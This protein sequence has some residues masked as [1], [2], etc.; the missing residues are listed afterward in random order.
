M[1]K[2]LLVSL[3]L[4]VFCVTQVF[5][6][7]RTITGTVT[8][9]DD[10]QPIPGVT[11]KIKGSNVGVPTDVN[12]KYS[13]NA[14]AG[15][16]LMFSFISYLTQEVSVGDRSV[17]NVSLAPDNKQLNEVLV[18]GYGQTTRQAYVGSAKAVSGE[19]LN[20][21]RV[22]NITQA[23]A[24]EVAG[25][26]VVNTSGQPGTVA[27]VRIRGFGS[28]NGNRDPLYVVDGVPYTGSLNAINPNDVESTTV[29]KDATATA[30]YGSRGSAGVIVITTKSGKNKKPYVEA[31]VNFGTNK[32]LIP[33]YDVITSP[34]QYVG[35]SWEG[36]YNEGVAKGNANPTNYANTRLF[37]SAGLP[38]HFNIWNLTGP[39]LV[40]PATRTVK[41]DAVRKYTP[42]KW[43]DYAFQSA[44]RT[45][46][47]VSLGG[48][49]ETSGYY[50][51][52]GYE[53]SKGYSIASDFQ[54]LTGRLNL[55][56]QIKPWLEAKMTSNFAHSKQNIG[57]QTE[58]S[59]S[60]FWFVDN[61]PPIYGL[62]LRDASGNFVPD[63]IFGGNQYDYGANGRK[64]GS[65]T[66]SIADTKYNTNRNDRNEFNGTA[67]LNA[68]I[69]PGLTFENTFGLQYYDLLNTQLTN[70]YYGSSASQNGSIYLHRNNLTNWDLL[71]LVRYKK[72]FGEHNIEAFVAHEATKWSHGDQEDFKYNLILN[73]SESLNNA[74]VSTPAT[75][76][77]EGYAIESYFGQINYDYQDK[78]FLLGSI[79]RDGSSRFLNNKWGTFGSIGAG[80]LISSEEFM[81]DQT[82][83]SSLKLKASYGT[84]GDQ[85]GVG[86]YSGYNLS[87]ISNAND[88][89]SIGVPDK[90]NPNLTWESSKILQAGVEFDLGRYLTG[91]LEYYVKNTSNLIFDQKK[92]LSNGYTQI[93]V[94]DGG[95]RNQGLEFDLVGHLV[96]NKD[97]R[98]DLGVN[99]EML[100]NRITSM[101]IDPTTGKQ[102]PI[103]TNSYYGW[104]AG[105]SI[106]DFY[107]RKS[108]GVNPADGRQSWDAYYVD[109]DGDGVAKSGAIESNTGEYIT[110]LVAYLA[111]HPDQKANIKETTTTTYT[112][113]A[114]QYVGK[115][116][117][118]TVR[119]A[120]NLN[121]GY[122][123]FDLSVQFLYSVGGYSYD[124]AYNTLMGNDLV[125]DNNWSTDILKRWQKPGDKTDVPRISDDYDV[126]STGASSRFITKA[127]YIQLNNVRLSY[128]FSK[129]MTAKW[130]VGSLGVFVSGDNL[131]M[132]SARKG[133]NP[134]NAED[135]L[136]S[137]YN[138][139]PLS[140][141]SAGLNVRF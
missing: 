127:S 72:Q 83:F 14:P 71:N 52:L 125:G 58:D 93:T 139:S 112:N 82:I 24:G 64:F 104:S 106:Y 75:S 96:R 67:S 130:G 107:M 54:R 16:T 90:G 47:N 59:G 46:T 86:Y 66:N 95:L 135:G 92:P 132:H 33:R 124:A 111:A 53:N 105:H 120:V 50:M 94:N 2:L 36:L 128:T 70:K 27:T 23:L 80:W 65:L 117:V 49:T 122:K 25:V 44:S 137:I 55:N 11:V 73:N 109:L 100:K 51:S 89:R 110:N 20:K 98:L 38:S 61:L 63:P 3:C 91:S 123:G 84:V 133:F 5:A 31:N 6:Q 37:S 119:G 13:I 116:F 35:L 21:K 141:L 136:S 12:G 40:D 121:A 32:N 99:G 42:E 69:I 88:N 8:G 15:S 134:G 115:S 7:N 97:F 48:G 114:L 22:D 131:Y 78:Y 118:P 41:S 81:K 30:I 26:R 29:L 126:L 103:Q 19:E 76:Y 138:Y 18:V 10:G 79:R 56:S 43:A 28:V 60:I 4:L 57:G 17:I 68:T 74:V 108:T 87:T 1:K 9:Q 101:P 129:A 113:A 85:A 34:E 102:I 39:N 77:T 62:F 45:E 140:T